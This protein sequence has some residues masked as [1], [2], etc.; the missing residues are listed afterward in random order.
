MVEDNITKMIQTTLMEYVKINDAAMF[1]S[2]GLMRYVFDID[3]HHFEITYDYVDRF[4]RIIIEKRHNNQLQNVVFLTKSKKFH[5][6]IKRILRKNNLSKK[7]FEDHMNAFA[8]YIVET[9]EN[10]N[11]LNCLYETYICDLNFNGIF[12]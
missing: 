3:Y 12:I 4:Y 9:L 8:L 7:S 11:S 5:K 2:N 10:H 6:D 1:F